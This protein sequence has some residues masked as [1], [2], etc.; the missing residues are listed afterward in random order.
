MVATLEG[1][2]RTSRCFFITAA[3]TK[4]NRGLVTKA[5]IDALPRAAVVVMVSRAHLVD[6]D[7]LVAAAGEGRIR[8]AIDVFPS[9][10]LPEDHPLRSMPNVILSPHRAAAV[11]GGRQLMGR[12]A[13]EDIK[14]MIAGKEP[15]NLQRARP[16]HVGDLAGVQHSK[17]LEAMADERE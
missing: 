17:K 9:E 15:A 14:L 13:V 6:F 1:L 16:E 2:A 7:A 3:P 5:V 4:T 8:A 10:P 11:S 12:L